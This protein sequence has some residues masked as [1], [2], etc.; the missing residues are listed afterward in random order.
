MTIRQQWIAVCAFLLLVGTG[1]FA[2]T[3]LLGD[4]LFL[5]SVG[6]AA[7]A[8]KAVTLDSSPRPKTLADYRG[9]VVLLNVWATWCAPCRVEMPSIQKLHESYG[10]RGLKVVAVSIDDPGQARAIREFSTDFRL[11]FEILHD[12]SG[13]IRRDYQATGVPETFILGRDGVIRKKWIG[14]ADWNSSANR[15]LIEQ[16]LAEKAP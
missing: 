15:A 6:S 2:A 9:D 13:A 10:S 7:P 4:Q 5:V 12:Q 11:T 3:A 16:L 8:F 14:P 1:V